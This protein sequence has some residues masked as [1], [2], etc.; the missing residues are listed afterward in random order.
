MEKAFD[1]IRFNFPSFLLISEASVFQ[2]RYNHNINNSGSGGGS[3]SSSS[4]SNTNTNLNNSIVTA[5]R[6]GVPMLPSKNDPI[7]SRNA[8]RQNDFALDINSIARVSVRPLQHNALPSP[9]QDL[10][11]AADGS[12]P[13]FS[14]AFFYWLFF[15]SQTAR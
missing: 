15:R 7:D 2:Q 5:R 1:S 9:K 12:G 14:P 4:G 3:S 10:A 6:V 8:D 13:P 11:A